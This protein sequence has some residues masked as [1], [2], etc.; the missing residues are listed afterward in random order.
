MLFRNKEKWACAF[1]FAL[2]GLVYGSVMSRIP[3]LKVQTGLNE[4]ELGTALLGLGLGALTSFPIMGYVQTKIGSRWLLIVGAVG[5]LLAFPLLSLPTQWTTFA[6]AFYAL[7]FCSGAVE[8]GM[9]TQAL[10]V[11]RHLQKPA[12]SGL[13]GMYS[14]GSL[15]GALNT[16]IFGGSPAQAFVITAVVLFC[17][18]PFACLN[19]LHDTP[20]PAVQK[21]KKQLPPPIIFVMGLLAM[22]CFVA[23]GSVGDWGALFLTTVRGYGEQSAALGYAAFSVAMVFGR[24][25]GD[26]LRS[27]FSDVPLMRV[28]A[29]IATTGIL[30]LLYAPWP[31][32]SLIG[33]GLMGLGLSVIV[34]IIFSAVGRCKTVD[35]GVGV[36]FVSTFGYVGLLMGPPLIGIAAHNIGLLVALNVVIVLCLLL[37]LGAGKVSQTR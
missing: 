7:G 10:L 13:H 34:P 23:E 16:V 15:I 31:G 2:A 3:A 19:L 9:G 20:L 33:F 37:F 25:A 21:N 24:L 18:W 14:L 17:L 26:R 12:M 29:G 6:L 30:L 4:A 11:E 27:Q 32:F 8:V 35:P 36:A 1:F 28:L 22:C 5:F